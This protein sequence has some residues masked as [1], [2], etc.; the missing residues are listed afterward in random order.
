MKSMV[1]MPITVSEPECCIA[2]KGTKKEK[3]WPLDYDC[4]AGRI[5]L[6]LLKDAV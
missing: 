6:M 4:E 2:G 1:K 5:K 3:E